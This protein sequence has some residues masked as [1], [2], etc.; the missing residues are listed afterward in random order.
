MSTKNKH[1]PIILGLII[2][3]I[4]AV[5]LIWGKVAAKSEMILF[6]GDGCPHCEIVDD[7]LTENNTRDRLNF[8]ELEIYNNKDNAR[9]LGQKAK[10]CGFDTSQGVGVPFLS[11]GQKCLIGDKDIIDYFKTKLPS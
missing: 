9:L 2:I 10:E 3:A 11:D 6:Y 5:I 4:I 8:Q 1:K 7:Y